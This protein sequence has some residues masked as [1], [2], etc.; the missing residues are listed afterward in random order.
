MNVSII[1]TPHCGRAVFLGLLY[2][3]LIRMTAAASDD[4]QKVIIN[5]G[6]V[7]GQGLRGP[8]PGT[9]FGKVAFI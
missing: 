5:T 6:L 8:A 9:A 2:E 4:D 1:G 7:G 3:T